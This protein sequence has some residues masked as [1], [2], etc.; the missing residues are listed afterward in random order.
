MS[1]NSHTCELEYIT[2]ETWL[3]WVLKKNWRHCAICQDQLQPCWKSDKS[4]LHRYLFRDLFASKLARKKCEQSTHGNCEECNV[5]GSNWE[6]WQRKKVRAGKSKRENWFLSTSIIQEK[7]QK[8]K[9]RTNKRVTPRLFSS[10]FFYSKSNLFSLVLWINVSSF[11]RVHLSYL[12]LEQSS[13]V[14]NVMKKESSFFALTF[15]ILI[16]SELR[17]KSWA[18]WNLGLSSRCYLLHQSSFLNRLLYSISVLLRVNSTKLAKL[19]VYCKLKDSF[20]S[21]LLSFNNKSC[22]VEEILDLWHQQ[23][24]EEEDVTK[25]MFQTRFDNWSTEIC[26]LVLL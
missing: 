8:K 9:F 22:F 12:N 4:I 3:T 13:L 19:C 25:K 16:F 18:E 7:T 23:S 5:M 14:G 17:S 15:Q 10:V 21:F 24:C 26:V 6:F 1:L 20:S 11:S 2:L